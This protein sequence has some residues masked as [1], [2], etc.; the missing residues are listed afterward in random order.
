MI[1]VQ[2]QVAA[3]TLPK[4]ITADT[5]LRRISVD[6]YHRLIKVGFFAPEERLELIEGL[7]VL[8]SP[9]YPPHNGCLARLNRLFVR[10]IGEELADIRPQ[11]P[12]TFAHQQSEPQPDLAV[13][14]PEPNQYRRRNPRGDEVFLV[15]EVSESSLYTDRRVKVPLYARAGI[16]EYWI[17]NLRD[18]QIEVYQQPVVAGRKADYQIKEVY[19]SGD[20][21][22]PVAF[23][24][25]QLAVT[26]ILGGEN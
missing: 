21:V 1:E 14:Q 7:M 24:D 8:M 13:V 16:Q 25:C 22:A 4:W 26:D 3:P 5:P 20:I 18:R 10:H 11:M 19:R 9:I 2:E 12:L 17:V 15:I 23:P 6:E